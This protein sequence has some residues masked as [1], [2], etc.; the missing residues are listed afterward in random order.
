MSADIGTVS[1][2][3]ERQLGLALAQLELGRC[4]AP[5]HRASL[6]RVVECRAA[7]E[8]RPTAV[9]WSQAHRRSR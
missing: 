5:G 6:L 2:A 4:G 7:D 3:L 9:V 1:E 8:G